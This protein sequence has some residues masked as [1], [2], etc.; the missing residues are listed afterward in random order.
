MRKMLWAASAAIAVA[1]ILLSAYLVGLIGGRETL[2]EPVIDPP[3]FS[4]LINNPYLPFAPGTTFI[5]EGGGY[6]L[7]T[8]CSVPPGAPPENVRALRAAADA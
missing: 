2:Y 4:T 7:S 5:Y 6:I 3:D 1:A 8:A